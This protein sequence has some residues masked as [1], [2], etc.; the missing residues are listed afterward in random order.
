LD[1]HATVILV[2]PNIAA[3]KDDEARLDLLFIENETHVA[4]CHC[5]EIVQ[6]GGG[7]A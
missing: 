7:S 4:V 5:A 2:V 6:F 1:T 3:T